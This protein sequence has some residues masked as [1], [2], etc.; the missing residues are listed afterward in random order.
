MVGSLL[1]LYALLIEPN[2]VITRKYYVRT[3]NW[4]TQPNLKIAL[5]SD[6]HAIEPWMNIRKIEKIVARTNALDADLILLLGDYAGTH[7]FGRKI[8]PIKA[9]EP[10]LKLNVPCCTFAIMGDHDL[11]KPDIGWATAIRN[12]GLE[13]L[14]G[15]A[16]KIDHGPHQFWITGEKEYRKETANPEK[17]LEQVTDDSP[18]IMA[19]HNPDIFAETPNHIALSVAGH[20]H[21]G[22]VRLPFIGAWR[23]I[24]PSRYGKRFL[25]GHIIEND[26]H[27]VVSA[28]LGCSGLPLRFM[29]P[30]EIVLISLSSGTE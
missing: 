20:M 24:L 9:M 8:D 19:M 2:R 21:R 15:R 26:S 5:I 28:G 7:V 17:T 3:K 11:Q 6:V 10:F 18:T 4:K 16:V 25:H 12:S 29:A 14:E 30:P 23:A 13:L 22:Q 27:L 1:F